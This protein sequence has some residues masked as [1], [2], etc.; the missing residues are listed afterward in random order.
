MAV[1]AGFL[2]GAA[3]FLAAP[4]AGAVVAGC[5][6]G[7]L[8]GATA[9]TTAGFAPPELGATA[10]TTAGLAAALAAAGAPL[11]DAPAL[12]AVA[13][14]PSG[15][16]ITKQLL[17]ALKEEKTIEERDP[18]SSQRQVRQTPPDQRPV[19]NYAALEGG[20]TGLAPRPH[21]NL[22]HIGNAALIELWRRCST[23][24]P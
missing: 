2:A 12:F 15:V 8:F 9:F 1:A 22:P 17:I 7:L 14:M 18:G 19:W 13:D 16:G 11:T 20:W 4:D 10:L 24:R 5:V 21:D 3:G 23:D 6:A